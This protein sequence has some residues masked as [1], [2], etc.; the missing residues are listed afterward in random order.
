MTKQKKRML[1][2]AGAF[3][4]ILI[5]GSLIAFFT[6]TEQK[7]NAFTVGSVSIELKEDKYKDSQI[8]Y[9]N[10][11]IDKNPSVKNIGENAAYVFLEVDV[12]KAEITLLNSNGEFLHPQHNA[13]GLVIENY[14]S[15]SKSLQE[16]FNIT[17]TAKENEALKTVTYADSSANSFSYHSTWTQLES[18][19]NRTDAD[20]NK[21]IFYYNVPLASGSRTDTLFDKVQLKNFIDSEFSADSDKN[22]SDEDVANINV[23]AYAIQSDNLE[24]MT[25]TDTNQATFYEELYSIIKNRL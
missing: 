2:G 15:V 14:N 1:L 20:Y 19:T 6:E 5:I 21:Y 11:N 9:P 4:T 7:T 10:G 24:N 18:K 25:N 16:I 23:R 3:C 22:S 12:P 8:V 17:S 13:N